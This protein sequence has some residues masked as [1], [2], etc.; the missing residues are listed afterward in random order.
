[1]SVTFG[2]SATREFTHF[3]DSKVASDEVNPTLPSC[4][5]RCTAAKFFDAE[6]LR[7]SSSNA[8][9][10]AYDLHQDAFDLECDYMQ[11]A[12]SFFQEPM[13]SSSRKGT[14]AAAPAG[15]NPSPITV[16]TDCSGMEA[17]I[18]AL[19][20]LRV[21]YS[22]TFSCDNDT[23]VRK[24]IAANYP[25]DEL[26]DDITTRDV[27]LTPTVDLYVAGFPCQPFSSAG[28]QQ[29]FA[30][31][32][33]RG[34]I[35]Y[36]VLDYIKTHVPKVFILENVKGLTTLDGG[37][38]LKAIM[39]A[40]K[41]VSSNKVK[42]KH[43]G[44]TLRCAYEIH[45]KVLNT[46]DHGVAQNRPRWYCIGIR[47]DT[48][49]PMIASSFSWPDEIECPSIEQFLDPPNRENPAYSTFGRQNATAKTNITEAKNRINAAGQHQPLDTPYIVDCDASRSKSKYTFDYSPCITR[50]RGN[51]HWITNRQRRFSK[52]E[53]FRLQ[54]M[55]H[56]QF[57]QVVSDT[58]LGHQIGNAMS[59]NVIERVLRSSLR[60][61]GLSK[62]DMPDRWGSGEALIDLQK[63]IGKPFGLKSSIK[64]FCRQ[65]CFVPHGW[66]G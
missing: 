44:A 56:S 26:Q 23:A 66:Q 63:S 65:W 16:G 62:Q 5:G 27:R 25:P 49:A 47:K 57:T 28:K 61:A 21:P 13:S 1:V 19:R 38:H 15:G 46:R 2:Q 20:N 37:K 43:N 9:K 54:G 51:G 41:R 18:Q 12:H 14:A 39:H 59:V 8:L 29:G 58:A 60:A 53:M 33:G 22:H 30:D 35:F 32:K 36:N 50:S 45:H 48:F 7:V 10:R 31:S 11:D 4:A 6:S 52:P 55:D 17:P 34:V 3:D 24:T 42:N 40:L 64:Q